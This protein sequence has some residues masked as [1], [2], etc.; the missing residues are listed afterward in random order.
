MT[1]GIGITKPAALGTNPASPPDMRRW[2]RRL[3]R[4]ASRAALAGC[5][6]LLLGGAASAQVAETIGYTYDALGR[7]TNVAHTGTVNNNVNAAY[8]LDPAGNRS[9]VTVTTTAPPAAPSFAINSASATEG[10]PIT[11]TVTKTGT[12]SSTFTV[13]YATADGTAHAGTDYNTASSTLTFAATDTS[14]TFQVTTIGNSIVDGTRTFSV[15]LSGASGGASITT[16]TGTGTINDDDSPPP[17][18]SINSA[19][20][21]EGGALGFTVTRSGTTTGSYTVHFATADGTAHA[22]TDYT[23]N[24]NTLTFASGVTSQ[25]ISVSTTGNTVVDGTR[26]LSVVLSSA[27]GGATITSG[28]GTG[29]IFDNDGI[30]RI[31]GGSQLNSGQSWSSPDGR[32]KLTAQSDFNVVLYQGAT[33]LWASGTAGAGTMGRL[34]F[35]NDGNL[36]LYDSGGVARWASNTS[37]NTGAVLAIQGDGNVVIYS[38]TGT[39]LWATGTGGH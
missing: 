27:S 18:F 21:V 3:L 34:V 30:T 22:G 8:T 10:S 5:A 26:T 6:C 20:A 36:V 1:S 29:T 19:Q 23:A 16:G 7:L 33:A 37:G 14:K 28:T 32:F 13:N 15:N 9:N 24:A 11:F 4:G 25:P 12:T 38:S 39:P 31:S 35:Q 17:S 2:R